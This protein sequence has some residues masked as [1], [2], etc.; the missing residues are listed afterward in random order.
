MT[1]M[2]TTPITRDPRNG[3]FTFQV[4]AEYDLLLHVQKDLDKHRSATISNSNSNTD[5]QLSKIIMQSVDEY[6]LRKQWMYHIGS[7]KGVAIG[8]FLREA[9]EKWYA[10]MKKNGGEAKVRD[11]MCELLDCVFVLY[12]H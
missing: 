11:I 4:H 5:I 7:E 2:P 6:C 3:A 8:R 12:C 9:A 1:P 10:K